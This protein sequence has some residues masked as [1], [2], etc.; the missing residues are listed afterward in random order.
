MN[1]Y[2]NKLM[3][4]HFVHQLSREGS[5]VSAI[6]K[7][8]VMD[9]RTVRKYLDMSEV[10]YEQFISKQSERKRELEPYDGFVKSRLS[11][12]P[13]TSAAQMHDWLKEHYPEFPVVDS[14]T[15]F[16]FVCYIRQKYQI[17]KAE[18]IR[19]HS[20]VPETPYGAQAQADLENTT[21]VTTSETRSGYFS[22]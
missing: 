8:L 4:Y 1:A 11:K 6:C 14:K 17:D 22:L 19:E 12:Y 21:Y 2:A 20:M 16:N 18:H 10:E 7:R 15:V 5:S 13:E 9:W 3:T